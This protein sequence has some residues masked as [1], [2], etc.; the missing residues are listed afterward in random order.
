MSSP[1]P[2][3]TYLDISVD[4]V[5]NE[6]A[7]I[8]QPCVACGNAGL[9][10][11]LI[12]P[13]MFFPDSL[14]STFTCRVCPFRN[15]QMDEMNQS[16]KGVRI[17]CYLDKPED[18]KR[19]LIIPS[20]AKVS[21]ESGLDGVA[22]THQEDS[23]STVESLIRGIFEKLLSISTLPEDR[24]TKEELLELEEYSGVA[25]FLQDS[26][27]NLNMTLSIDDPKGVARV[28]P[29]GANMQRSTKNI[30]LDYYRDGVVE[31][32]E[33]DLEPE[34]SGE[35]KT[36]DDLVEETSHESTSPE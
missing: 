23:V 21:F 9:L 29:I 13:D 11:L 24:L 31:I 18:L 15:K 17:S 6:P 22:Y 5:P 33:Y 4:L 36:A 3:Q 2:E 10:R 7:E 27:D 1:D 32:E 35:N 34:N 26:M 19:Y 28:M 30:P 12:V 8:E 16:N 14:I 20:K 25:T